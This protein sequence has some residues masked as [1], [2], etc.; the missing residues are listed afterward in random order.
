MSQIWSPARR[1]LISKI[2]RRDT[3]EE[4][5]GTGA[6]K[7]AV[8][9]WTTPSAPMKAITRVV[10][11]ERHNIMEN[12]EGRPVYGVD[13]LWFMKL[14]EGL[15]CWS[16]TDRYS[17]SLER[18]ITVRRPRKSFETTFPLGEDKVAVNVTLRPVRYLERWNVTQDSS[19]FI[20]N[21]RRRFRCLLD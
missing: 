18:D 10:A 2:T 20:L 1:P 11:M 6:K 17:E 13:T 5:S 9:E 7:E 8:E 3:H 19:T 14:K 21:R 15:A 12:K 4:A 16:S